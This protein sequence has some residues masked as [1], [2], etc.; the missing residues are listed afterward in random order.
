MTRFRLLAFIS[1]AVSTC[2]LPVRGQEEITENIDRFRPD[3]H[4]PFFIDHQL[5]KYYS[6][7]EGR[8][9]MESRSLVTYPTTKTPD[10]APQQLQRFFGSMFRSIKIRRKNAL[11]MSELTADPANFALNER[12]EITI[13]FGVRNNTNKIMELDFPSSQRL[14]ILVKNRAGEVIERWSDDQYFD[15][16]PEVVMVNP[17]ERIEY[18]EMIPTREMIPGETYVIEASLHNNPEFTKSVTIT[19]R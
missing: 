8:N 10:S 19:P 14:E 11:A 2:I 9:Q 17:D 13:T 18:S 1:F 5:R 12:R 7:E 6:S 15:E 4:S 16:R 3:E